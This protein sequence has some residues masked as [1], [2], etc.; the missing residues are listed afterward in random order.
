VVIDAQQMCSRLEV[1]MVI[2]AVHSARGQRQGVAPS[3][4]WDLHCQADEISSKR[5]SIE[6]GEVGSKRP[7][8]GGIGGHFA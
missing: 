2:A 5:E 3:F 4:R 1:E 7:S 8:L 6:V